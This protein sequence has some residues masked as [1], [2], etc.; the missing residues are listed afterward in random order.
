ME[1]LNEDVFIGDDI[2]ELMLGIPWTIQWKGKLFP[3]LW[4]A[5]VL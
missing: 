5:Y 1:M 3:I 2:D 4:S